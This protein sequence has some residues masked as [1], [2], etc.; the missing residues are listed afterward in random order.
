[1]IKT[2]EPRPAQGVQGVEIGLHLALTLARADGPM[3]LGALAKAAGLPP[4]KTHRYLVSLCRAGLL[5]QDG[6]KGT[7]DLGPNAL[8]LGLAAQGRLD[9]YRVA[10]DAL[11]RL[12]ELTRATASAIVW[13]NYGPTIVRRREALRA[14]TVNTRI[15]S[16]LPVIGSASGRVFAAFL[17]SPMVKPLIESEFA[18]GLRPRHRGRELGERGFDKLIAEIA[19]L[20]LSTAEGDLLVGVDAIAAPVF[21]Q[22]GDLAMVLSVVGPQGSF[23]MDPKAAPSRILTEIVDDFSHRLGYRRTT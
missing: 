20:R 3:A 7:Y 6:R 5:E 15:G 18:R 1:M 16:V 11:E 13:G 19:E 8:V 23:A 21:D 12:H 17:P 9:I 2:R 10:E 14:I 4:S 22:K